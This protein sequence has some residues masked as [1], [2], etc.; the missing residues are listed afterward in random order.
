MA[1]ALGL[2]VCGSWS[3]QGVGFLRS[4]CCHAPGLSPTLPQPLPSR[5]SRILPH[6]GGENAVAQGVPAEPAQ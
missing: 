6:A 5:L 3:E 4:P 1:G 2:T